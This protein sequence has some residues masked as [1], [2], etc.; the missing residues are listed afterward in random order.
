MRERASGYEYGRVKEAN[1]VKS[2]VHGRR[3]A[4]RVWVT[5]VARE[6]KVREVG[7]V[8]GCGGCVVVVVV[9]AL[10]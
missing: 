6:M 8:G 10:P 7:E 1:G 9:V 4:T 5:R 3:V 2:S